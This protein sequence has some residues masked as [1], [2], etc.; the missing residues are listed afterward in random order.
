MNIT[1]YFFKNEMWNQLIPQA[2]SKENI[3]EV[4]LLSNFLSEVDL[5]FSKDI[6]EKLRKPRQSLNLSSESWQVIVDNDVEISFLYD[7]SNSEYK[8]SIS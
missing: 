3:K 7:E 6:L 2:K 1:Y 4:A 8:A 5:E